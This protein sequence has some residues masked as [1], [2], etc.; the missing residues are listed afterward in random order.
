MSSRQQQEE[1]LA[2]PVQLAPLHDV[3][4]GGA[5]WASQTVQVF[6]KELG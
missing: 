6:G 3:E 1:C 5:L 2:W 4:K